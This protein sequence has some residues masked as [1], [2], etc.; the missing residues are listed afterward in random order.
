[1]T[2]LETRKGMQ[3]MDPLLSYFPAYDVSM[4]TFTLTYITLGLFIISTIINPKTFIIAMQGYCLL[5]IMRTIS[6]Y[7]VALEPPLGMILLKDPVTIIFMSTP[8]GGYIVKDL[9]FSGHVSTAMLFFII[10]PNQIIK[11]ALLLLSL[12]ISAFILIQHVHYTIDVIAAPFFS[13]LAYKSSLF[14]DKIIH[15]KYDSAITVKS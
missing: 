3:L 8:D 9:F 4:I 12:L 6:I 11:K 10:C 13:F 15:Q 5:I 2:Q 1:M 7:F 14:L